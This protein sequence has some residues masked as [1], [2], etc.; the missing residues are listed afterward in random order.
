VLDP[1][2]LSDKLVINRALAI[3]GIAFFFPLGEG[4]VAQAISWMHL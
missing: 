4:S 2:G 3:Y 1:I